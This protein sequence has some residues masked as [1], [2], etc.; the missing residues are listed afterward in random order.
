MIRASMDFENISGSMVS[1]ILKQTRSVIKN[2]SWEKSYVRRS[3]LEAFP[4]QS[5]DTVRLY[6]CLHYFIHE[7]LI[8]YSC[9][10][11]IFDAYRL[12][13]PIPNVSL[14]ILSKIKSSL[15]YGHDQLVKCLILLPTLARNEQHPW[16]A[17][18]SWIGLLY[19]WS[20]QF[21]QGKAHGQLVILARP[22]IT[23]ALSLYWVKI[24]SVYWIRIIRFV[25][26]YFFTG[27]HFGW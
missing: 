21:L 8:M 25:S 9:T 5:W 7:M 20:W 13:L 6:W 23:V 15:A 11:V 24:F 10:W 22:I 4:V 17:I 3:S 2:L 26:K 1:S 27:Y 18:V 14:P 19:S 12:A 16:F